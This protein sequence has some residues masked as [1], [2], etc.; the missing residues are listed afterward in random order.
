M[1]LKPDQRHLLVN[2]IQ[3]GINKTDVAKVFGVTRK[4]VRKWV[5]RAQHDHKNIFKDK[6]R[7]PKKSKITEQIEISILKMRLMFKWGTA[8]IQQGLISLPNYIKEKFSDLIQ[9]IKLSRTTI[10]NILKEHKLNGYRRQKKGWKFFRAKKSNELWQLDLKGPFKIEGKKYWMVA[11][12]DD[13]SRNLLVNEIVDFCPKTKTITDLLKKLPNKPEKILVDN[14]G[15]FQNQWKDWCKENNIEALFAHPYYPQD[16]GKVERVIRT[17]T[18]EFIVLLKKFPEW[19]KRTFD[20]RKWY[21]EER[22][23][24]G[25]KNY[26]AKI[27]MVT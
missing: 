22:Y 16:K 8:K 23:H 13:Y 4:T 3:R 6:K 10:N 18:E 19:L 2:A 5:K 1:K 9:E 15:Q 25:I 20:Y 21:N 26:P 24:R 7:K 17:I 11:V 14:G 12:I 27:Y